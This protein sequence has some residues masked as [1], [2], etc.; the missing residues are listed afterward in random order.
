MKLK[1]KRHA[2][3]TFLLFQPVSNVDEWDEIRHKFAVATR[4]KQEWVVRA[5][6]YKN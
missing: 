3:V 2:T 5:H 4:I 1:T 6:M